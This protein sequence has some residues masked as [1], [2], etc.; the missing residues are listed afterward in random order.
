LTTFVP[1]LKTQRVDSICGS[2]DLESLATWM[3][4]RFRN[5]GI[6]AARLERLELMDDCG[7]SYSIAPA[8]RGVPQTAG[9]FVSELQ[10]FELVGHFAQ[11]ERYN[12]KG[13]AEA[14]RKMIHAAGNAPI[15]M[16]CFLCPPYIGENT[17]GGSVRYIGVHDEFED[18]PASYNFDYHYKLYIECVRKVA[19]LAELRGVSLEPIVVFSDWALIGIDDI[20]KTLGSD[21]TIVERMIRFR[22]GMSQYCVGASPH[23]QV[24]SFRDLGVP[25]FFPLGLPMDPALRESWLVDYARV[26]ADAGALQSLLAYAGN[27]ELLKQL[28][29]WRAFSS[30]E[31]SSYRAAIIDCLK[32]YHNICRLRFAALNP[33]EQRRLGAIETDNG[34]EL[35]HEAFVD[36]VLRFVQYQLYSRLFVERFGPGICCYQDPGFT[37]CGN[38]FRRSGFP[39]LFLDPNR[40]LAASCRW[41]T[42]K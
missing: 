26:S 16:A 39:V 10:S 1:L 33:E 29:D 23:V 8:P 34:A 37:A 14:I 40:V 19:C 38:L 9:D 13:D 30:I 27:P 21:E 22:D 11:G 3:I 41:G 35:R 18:D 42:D 6:G 12:T 25:N 7:P 36:A 32:V 2:D 17:A 28:L 20:R 4:A 5:R 31:R 24:S 15:P